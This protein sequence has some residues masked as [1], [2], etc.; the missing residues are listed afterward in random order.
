MRIIEHA[1]VGALHRTDVE[2]ARA[3]PNLHLDDRERR[4]L[5]LSAGAG[6]S[7]N[8]FKALGHDGTI[9]TSILDDGTLERRYRVLVGLELFEYCDTIAKE[10]FQSASG[11]V[12]ALRLR[13][14]VR[15]IEQEMRKRG[16][17]PK[18]RPDKH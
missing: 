7:V 8:T 3:P 18:P 14:I 17:K 4:N 11:R 16:I 1:N 5:V 2:N 15:R 12:G 6:L 10:D 13:A 9:A